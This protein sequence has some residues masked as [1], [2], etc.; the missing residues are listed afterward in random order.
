MKKNEIFDIKIEKTIFGGEGLGYYNDKVIFVPMAVPG[1]LLRV[2]LISEKK[3]YGRALIKEV[4]EASNDRVSKD[5]ISFEDYSGCDFAMIKYPAQ[6]K[7]KKEILKEVMS[8]IARI[9]IENIDFESAPIELN[10]RNKVAEP[11]VKINGEIK[12]GFYKK[13]SH[14]IF[15]TDVINLRSKVATDIMSK[16]LEKLNKFKGTK[17]EFKVYNEI[18]NSGF[19]KNCVVRN[20]ENNEVMLVIVVTRTSN[21]K[22]LE[23]VLKELYDENEN[24]KSIYISIKDKVD[25]VIFGEKNMKI[26]GEDY[27]TENLMGINFRIYPDSFFQINKQQT[28]KLYNDALNLLGDYKDKTLIDAFSGTGTIAMIMSK[29]AK[30]VIG[31]EMTSS[32]VKAAKQTRNENKIENVEFLCGKVEDKIGE[33]LNKKTI[34]Y[35]LFDPPRKGIEKQVLLNVSEKNIKRLVYISCNPSTLARDIDIMIKEGYSVKYIKGYDMFPQ[36]HHIETLVLLERE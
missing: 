21:I 30:D 25:N 26:C 31:I 4:L 18:S 29:K 17:R 12:T 11:F 6:I 35:I 27:I 14:E 32:S 16:L 3:T 8:K 2:E 10:Y 28:V 33:I 36:T 5:L 22:N 23:K 15:T 9:N 7:Y 34:D 24:L 13:K 1:D 20:N 19:L